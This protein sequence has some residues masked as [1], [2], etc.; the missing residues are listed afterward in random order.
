[1]SNTLLYAFEPW[2]KNASN[3]SEDV[4]TK[5][6]LSVDKVN[7][8]VRFEKHIF[9]EIINKGHKQIIG[10]GQYPSGDL[11]RIEKI[12]HNAYGSKAM[13]YKVIDNGPTTLT[14]NLE[15]IPTPQSHITYD[16]GKFV[17][18]YS[19]YV[20]LREKQI[21]QEFAFLHIPKNM[22]LD[23]A[24]AAVREILKQVV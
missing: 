9:P 6:N 1:M 18:N 10:L 7:V 4:L 11:I 21:H 15:L 5:L 19:M 13:G 17:C 16:A 8:Q 22:Y 12:A 20:I 23:A 2:G 3:I 14:T 24:V